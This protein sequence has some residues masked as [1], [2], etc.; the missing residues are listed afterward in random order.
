MLSYLI[1]DED[2]KNKKRIHASFHV[3][4]EHVRKRVSL[5]LYHDIKRSFTP[6]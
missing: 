6:G 1:S 5:K 4:V 3:H 2:L